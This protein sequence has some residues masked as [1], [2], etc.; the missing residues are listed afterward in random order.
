MKYSSEE[1]YKKHKHFWNPTHSKFA[2][3]ILKYKKK[4]DLLDIGSG[5]GRNAVFLA[6]KGFN[7]NTIDISPTAIKKVDVLA[8]K[9][10]VNI[11][12]NVADIVK[13]KFNK[14]YDVITSFNVFMFLNKKALLDVI[15]K[16]KYNTKNNGLNVIKV[17]TEKNPNKN[18]PYLFIKNELSDMYADWEI[19]IYKEIMMGTEVHSDGKPHKH[20]IAMIIARKIL[21]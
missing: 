5:E 15:S 18:F 12:S 7:V 20:H 14:K 13:Y 11:I 21:K 9:N 3:V 4:G 10:N 1:L 2:E 17:F 6:E 19:L 16:I 8:K